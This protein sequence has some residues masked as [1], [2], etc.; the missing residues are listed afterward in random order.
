MSTASDTRFWDRTSRKY[1]AAAIADQAG[2]ERTLERR[3]AKRSTSTRR[4]LS[5]PLPVTW[6]SRRKFLLKRERRQ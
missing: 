1:A 5:R 2:Y 3:R 4:L 6:V